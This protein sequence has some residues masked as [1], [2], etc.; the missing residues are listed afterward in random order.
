MS[1]GRCSLCYLLSSTLNSIKKKIFPAWP[2]LY[3]AAQS[4]SPSLSW[5]RDGSSGFQPWAPC[6]KPQEVPACNGS[7]G[8]SNPLMALQGQ[9]LPLKDSEDQ[10]PLWQMLARM[11][12][13]TTSYLFPPNYTA[14][15]SHILLLTVRLKHHIPWSYLHN[16]KKMLSA[17]QFHVEHSSESRRQIW[18]KR[19]L[20]RE[21]LKSRRLNYSAKKGFNPGRHCNT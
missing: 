3:A 9:K 17:Q 10:K 11:S 21:M 15:R 20:L 6:W 1:S 18:L 14:V 16:P 12:V 2:A 4:V 13:M 19:N 8:L 7:P 5:P